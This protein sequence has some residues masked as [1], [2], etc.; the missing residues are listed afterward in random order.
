[1][2]HTYSRTLLVLYSQVRYKCFCFVSLL[3]LCCCE[4]FLR[5][6]TKWISLFRK[7]YYTVAASY[8]AS[9]PATRQHTYGL[10]RVESLAALLSMISLAFVSI[11]LAYEAIK[12]LVEPPEKKTDGKLMSGIATIGVFVNIILAIVLRDNHVHMP[13]AHDH[14][15]DGDECGGGG[16]DHNNCYGTTSS[17]KISH[18]EDNSHN[19]SHSHSHSHNNISENEDL[20][21]ETTKLVLVDTHH[22]HA[23]E[24][25]PP[26]HQHANDKRNVNL[27][28]AYLHVLGDLLQ[29]VAVL[30]A[31][32][33][34]WFRPEWH[35]IDPICTL[36]FC[37]IVFFSTFGVLKSAFSVLLEA[38]PPNIS[39]EQVY[40]A[41]AQTPNVTDVND[42]HIWS[43]S[44]GKPAL[45]VHCTSS[46]P[47]ALRNI[48]KICRNFGINHSTIQVNNANPTP[49]I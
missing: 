6:V 36:I 15:H 17:T 45:S 40:T 21:G 5:S 14:D 12:R 2:P 28:A 8:L 37:V 25:N 46:D 19:H 41:I 10:K 33:V 31:G 48:T 43:I 32:L 39:W 1:M 49:I 29:S 11:G 13:G 27:R 22:H 26:D 34:I 38:I 20:I 35:I 7:L 30:I 16:H 3:L 47:E 24:L 42:L 18:D 4:N 9:L 44:H 23:D